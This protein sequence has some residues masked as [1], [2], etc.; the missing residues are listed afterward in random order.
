MLAGPD[1][2]DPKIR[3]WG[4]RSQ[5]WVRRVIRTCQNPDPYATLPSEGSGHS[6]PPSGVEVRVAFSNGKLL[7]TSLA[8]EG[9][10]SLAR[11]MWPL[12]RGSWHKASLEEGMMCQWPQWWLE[13]A[14]YHTLPP[15]PRPLVPRLSFH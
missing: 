14:L 11:L 8:I 5:F 10:P 1:I 12:L 13:S 3:Y 6:L 2:P 7:D 9:L 4:T 15:P